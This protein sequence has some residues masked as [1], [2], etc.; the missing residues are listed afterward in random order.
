[1]GLLKQDRREFFYNLVSRLLVLV[2]RIV[3]F[4][5]LRAGLSSVAA[6]A[7]RA[8]SSQVLSLRA[9]SCGVAGCSSGARV[10]AVAVARASGVATV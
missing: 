10:V 3:C 2:C 4:A 5:Q 6:A 9:G 8:A 1:M 7:F